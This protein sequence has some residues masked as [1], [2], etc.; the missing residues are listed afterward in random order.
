MG[1]SSPLLE[2]IKKMD[3]YQPTAIQASALPVT[4]EGFI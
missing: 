3:F 2:Q 1:I 4:L